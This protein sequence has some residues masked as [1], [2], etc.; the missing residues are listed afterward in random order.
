MKLRDSEVLVPTSPEE[1]V[2][3]F[4]DGRDVTV[5]AGGTIVMPELAAGGLRPARALLLTRAGLDEL[6]RENGSIRIG[7]AVPVARLVDEAPEPLATYAR[8]VGDYEIRAQG[9]IGGNLCAPAGH[10]SPR[11]DLQAPL[12]ALGA[13][14]RSAG[15]GGERTEPVED[16]L[17]TGAQGRLV[18]EIEIDEPKR[19]SSAR[20]DR[21]HAHSYSILS[22]AC[23]ETADG[24]RVAVAGAGARATRCP[25]VERALADGADAAA[26]AERVLDDV[27]PQDDA[28]ASAWYRTQMLPRLVA[29]A[30]REQEVG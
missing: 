7:A 28:L 8:H 30:L 15:A 27:E 18:L 9:T 24:I 19:A 13:R 23:A 6:R 29:R 5:L 14:V 26:A 1:A 11:G 12:L 16:F 10:E 25:S 22:V 2:R 20:L 17:G 4:G 21:P 3:A